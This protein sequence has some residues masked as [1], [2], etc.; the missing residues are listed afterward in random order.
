MYFVFSEPMQEVGKALDYISIKDNTSGETKKVFLE[1]PTDLWNK[2]QDRLTLW[3]DPGR[4]KTGLIPNENKGLPLEKGHHY[5]LTIAAN[6]KSAKGV[7]LKKPYTK[8]VFVVDSDRKQPNETTW[9]IN[10]PNKDS[11]DTLQIGFNE[12]MDAILAKETITIRDNKSGALVS[13]RFELTANEKQLNFY[14]KKAWHK[15]KYKIIIQALLEDLA[16]NNLNHLF[17]SDLEQS[18]DVKNTAT[19][20]LSFSIP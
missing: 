7:A 17:D 15:G 14:P 18:S 20:T 10:I 2:E 9:R 3:L 8:S 5:T 19:K 1:L 6:L 16:G 12:P 13:G 4:I 11:K